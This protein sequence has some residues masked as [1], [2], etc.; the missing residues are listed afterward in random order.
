M[1]VNRVEWE[2]LQ[3][4]GYLGLYLGLTR[5]NLLPST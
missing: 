5:L 3:Q 1:A 4:A 2:D